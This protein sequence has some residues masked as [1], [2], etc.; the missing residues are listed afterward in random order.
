MFGIALVYPKFPKQGDN[1]AST[2]DV[3]LCKR[4]PNGMFCGYF[5]NAATDF[6]LLCEIGWNV[7]FDNRANNY[8][9]E[10]L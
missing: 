9:A 3:T 2:I 8:D 10:N 6:I 1:T 4:V 7:S 5:W